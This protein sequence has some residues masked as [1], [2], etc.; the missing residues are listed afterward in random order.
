MTQ[1]SAREYAD[2]LREKN[3]KLKDQIE[4]VQEWWLLFN[5]CIDSEATKEKIEKILEPE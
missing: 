3:K 2:N 5:Q 1:F 4:A